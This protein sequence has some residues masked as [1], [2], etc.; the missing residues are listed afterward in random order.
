AP[1]PLPNPALALIT[2]DLNALETAHIAAE[3]GGKTLKALMRAK[4]LIALKDLSN[5]RAYVQ[6]IANIIPANGEAIVIGAGMTVKSVHTHTARA[7]AVNTTKNP[8]EV[9]MVTKFVNRATFNWQL[10]TDPSVETS[11]QTVGQG[12]KASFIA[13]GLISGT[14]YYFRVAVVDKNGQNPWSN[15]LNLI[16]A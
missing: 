2:A 11:W 4:R 9:K 10:C 13:E 14:R 8:G 5:L 15:V 6:T 7:F 12:T 3:G 1:N 16:A